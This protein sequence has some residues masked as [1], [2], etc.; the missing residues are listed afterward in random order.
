MLNY[1]SVTLAYLVGFLKVLSKEIKSHIR[2]GSGLFG[3]LLL[4]SSS[5]SGFTTGSGGTTS[6]W[7]SAGTDTGTDVGDQTGYVN[8][9]QGGGEK[10]WPEWFDGNAGGFDNLVQVI[11]V[12]LDIGVLEDQGGVGAAKFGVS[13]FKFFFRFF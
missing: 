10:A 6:G 12:D 5:W 11:S 7:G 1:S 8:T 9:G 13:H 2:V 4:G 3:G